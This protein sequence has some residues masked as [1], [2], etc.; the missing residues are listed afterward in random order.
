MRREAA[1]PVAIKAARA[2][3]RVLSDGLHRDPEATLKDSRANVVTWA[4][5]R[6]QEAI[7]SVIR[8]AFPDHGI[9]GEEGTTGDADAEHV[10]F[11]DPLDGTSNYANGWPFFGVSVAL[12]SAGQTVCGVV[13]DPYH[14]ELFAAAP[15]GGAT[16]NGEPLS[17]SDVDQLD[18]ALV[19]V[20][21][22][23]DD[24]AVI[25]EFAQLV[26]LVMNVARGVRFPGAP[27]LVLCAV[28]AGRLTAYCERYMDPWDIVAGGLI[29][30]EA[31][32]RL[33]RFDGQAVRSTEPADVVATNGPIHD[34]LLAALAAPDPNPAGR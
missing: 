26:E 21:A 6:S 19:V 16:R 4:D 13:Y 18:R 30:E 2:G 11:V 31:G 3:G 23:S 28:A 25:R 10:W 8:D 15:G 24:P 29:L 9:V 22:Q 32:G 27:A 17:V 34:E 5:V 1:L 33:T 20:Q 12:R 7:V 14:D